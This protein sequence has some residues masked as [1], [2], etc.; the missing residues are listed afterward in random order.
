LFDA[1][2]PDWDA[3]EIEKPG[4]SESKKK[5]RGH[6]ASAITPFLFYRRQIPLEFGRASHQKNEYDQRPQGHTQQ[7]RPEHPLAGIGKLH[8]PIAISL[9][10]GDVFQVRC[11]PP[12]LI[13]P[14]IL[15]GSPV[16]VETGDEGSP[17]V[18]APTPPPVIRNPNRRVPFKH[19]RLAPFSLHFRQYDL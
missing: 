12:V 13:G 7:K 2:E 4:Q 17:S 9:Q 16:R 8:V 3:L 15:P 1:W 6:R 18:I 19:C 11:G 10:I 5:E 14:A